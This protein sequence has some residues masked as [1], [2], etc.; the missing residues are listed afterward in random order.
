MK[1]AESLILLVDSP[2]FGVEVNLYLVFSVIS[3]VHGVLTDGCL[4]DTNAHWD[5]EEVRSTKSVVF[6]TALD[7]I[8]KDLRR[9]EN[10]AE[11]ALHGLRVFKDP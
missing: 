9:E 2:S 10:S 3:V 8:N 5:L 7:M 11:F 1:R 6:V 4:L